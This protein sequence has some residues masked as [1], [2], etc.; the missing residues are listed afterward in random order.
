[1]KQALSSSEGPASAGNVIAAVCSF[2]LPGL[3]QLVQGRPIT[4]LVH[5]LLAGI[6]WVISF[7][8]MGWIMHLWSTLSAA[9]YVRP[10]VRQRVSN[11]SNF[12]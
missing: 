2:F 9:M 5:F 7:G 4:A 6:I 1:M 3:G 12:E 8:T 10:D 11:T